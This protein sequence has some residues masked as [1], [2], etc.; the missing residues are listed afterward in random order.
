VSNSTEYK[1]FIGDD[2]KCKLFEMTLSFKE[3]GPVGRLWSCGSLRGRPQKARERVKMTAG[4]LGREEE[5]T[6]PHAHALRTLIF[7]LSL[8]FDACHAG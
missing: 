7:F 1:L 6:F 8:P 4:V 5:G 3:T 2:K